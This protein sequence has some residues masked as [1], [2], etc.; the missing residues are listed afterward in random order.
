MKNKIIIFSVIFFCLVGFV[1]SGVRWEEN[2]IVVSSAPGFQSEPKIISDGSGGAIMVWKDKRNGNDDIYAQRIDKDG[3]ILWAVDGSTICSADDHQGNPQI[4]SDGLGSFIIVWQDRRNSGEYDIYAQKVDK[5]GNIK[6]AENGIVVSSASGDQYY[7]Q[8][9]SDGSGGA[10]IV[11]ED[12]RN[13]ADYADIYAQRIDRDGNILWAVDGSTICSTDDC[14]GNP[15][16]ISDGSGG[17]IIVWE[18]YR[19]DPGSGYTDIYAQRIDKDG[20][21][22]WAVDGSTICSLENS[23]QYGPKITSDGCGGAIV[24][25][26]DERNGNSDIY[27]Q[28]IDSNGELQWSEDIPICSAENLQS[29][30]QILSDGLGCFIIVWQDDRN[31]VGNRDIYAQKID[32]YGKIKWAKDGVVICSAPYDQDSPQII[33]DGLGGA[34]ITWADYRGGGWPNGDIYA[35]RINKDGNVLWEVNGSTIC[36][37][38]GNQYSPTIASDGCGGAIVVWEDHRNDDNGDI[39][40]QRISNP[41]PEITSVSPSSAKPGETVNLTITGNWFYLDPTVVLSG[42]GITVNSVNWTSEQEIRANITVGS[43]ADLGKRNLTITN[44]DEQSVTKTL[45]FEVLPAV[46][47]ETSIDQTKDTTITLKAETGDIKLEIP[48]NTFQE[49]VNMTIKITETPTSDRETIKPT[50]ICIEITTDKSLQPNKEIIITMYY[51]DQDVAG[52]DETKLV[53]A[54]YDDKNK[55][56]VTLPSEVYPSENKVVGRTNHLS[57]FSIVQLSPANNLNELKVYPNPYNPKKHSQG[58]TIDGL[59]EEATIK[60]Y[61]ITGE[62]VGKVEYTTKDGRAI[63]YGKNDSGQEVACGVYIVFVDN[64]KEKKKIKLAVEK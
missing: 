42:S 59:T 41:A 46:E 40:A 50:N 7:P 29:V 2:G 21:I 55:R 61:T 6:W 13:H 11:W 9:I 19:N 52:F 32:A 17:A 53:I 36:S 22:L 37:A 15:Q 18:D 24:I 27:A 45:A 44:K 26:Q 25:W 10:I 20:N 30:L 12:Y 58:L 63:W 16:I 5:D 35:Q 57:K 14:Q 3:N 4:I 1:Y 51:R 8:I 38:E 31:G 64:G 54:R 43:T 23:D 56:W 39:Y 60:I 34:I 62:L 47:T 48:A 49:A 28:R 33:S